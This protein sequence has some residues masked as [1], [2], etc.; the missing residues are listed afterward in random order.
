[1]LLKSVH[2]LLKMLLINIVRNGSTTHVYNVLKDHSSQNRTSVNLL[3]LFVRP[4]MMKENVQL[5]LLATV[6]TMELVF[7][8][9][10]KT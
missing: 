9:V 2:P 10:Q 6:L 4:M 1:M 7:L 5:V 8:Q 3:T